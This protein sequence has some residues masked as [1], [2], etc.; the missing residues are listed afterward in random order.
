[1]GVVD[2]DHQIGDGELKLVHPEFAGFGLRREGVTGAEIEQD[3]GG[4]ADDELARF[5]ERRRKGRRALVSLHH[6]H[7]RSRAT[8]A[9]RNVVVSRPRFLQRQPYIFTAALDLGPVVELVFHGRRSVSVEAT[10]P[11]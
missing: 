1:M 3:V 2:L 11:M 10:E 5:Q 9:A 6:P 7:H 8:R 4:M